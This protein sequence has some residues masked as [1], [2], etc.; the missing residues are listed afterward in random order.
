LEKVK[1]QRERHQAQ[2]QLAR[3]EWLYRSAIEAAGAVPYCCDYTNGTFQFVGRGIEELTGYPP[4][5]FTPELWESLVEE[6][7]LLGEREGMRLEDA[8]RRART[9]RGKQLTADLRIRTRSGEQRWLTDASVQV[10]DDDCE[11][12]VGSMGMLADITERRRTEEALEESKQRFQSLF[13]N[14]PL[15]Y[16]SLNAN[17]DFVEVNET[18][19]KLLGYTKEE[20]L[21]RNFSEFIHPDF[22]EVFKENFPKFK[23]MGY[24]LG[25]EFEM[26][27]KDG[28]EIVVAFDGKIGCEPDGSFKQ[29]HCVLSDITERK[30]AEEALR[31]SEKR[32]RVLFESSR[33]AIMTLAPPSWDFT[34]G[35]PACIELFGARDEAEFTSLP[36][37]ELSPKHQPDGQL[38]ADKAKE[39]IDT[40][41]QEGSHFFEWMHKTVDGREFPANVLLTRVELAGQAL[42]EAT[43]R[44]ITERRRAEHELEEKQRHLEETLA[45][46]KAT[47][48]QIIAQERLRAL[49]QMASGVAH[50]LNNSLSPVL[51][52]AELAASVPDLPEKVRDWLG[53]VQTGARDAAAV[54]QRL[55]QFHRS[56]DDGPYGAVELGDLLRQIPELTRPKWRDEAQRTGRHI[57]VDLMLEDGL[58]VLGNPA[59]LREVFTNLVFNAVHAMPNGGQITLSLHATRESAVV[60]VTDTGIGMTDEVARRCFE[61]FFTAGKEEG[62]GLGMSVCHGIVQRHGGRIE[63]D[64]MPGCGTTVHVSLPMTRKSGSPAPEPIED[65]LP[66]RQPPWPK[67]CSIWDGAASDFS[68]GCPPARVL[69][70]R[71]LQR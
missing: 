29:T 53:W 45:E 51:G 7:V 40:A 70:I 12:S 27:K 42:L 57:E 41:M 35:N 26:I 64:T 17:G 2:E 67:S 6:T 49:G 31:E 61:P 69:F 60:E 48:Q 21:G 46:L 22:R 33:D 52:Y 37:W 11:L 9:E 71:A 38:S 43:V 8:E 34:S 36:P 44:D 47:Q 62:T 32:H 63:I 15:G 66:S 4:E 65:A 13:E 19:C 10:F 56:E 55:R 30:Q 28:S 58:C 16:Q 14:A 1:L 25:I 50:D 5:E 59:E 39:M 54:V 24:I 18:W 68:S 20:V 23:S 3:D